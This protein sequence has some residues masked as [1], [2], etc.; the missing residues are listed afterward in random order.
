[1]GLL[2]GIGE[3][4]PELDARSRL[5]RGRSAWGLADQMTW[6]VR[7]GFVLLGIL[8]IVILLPDAVG[9]KALFLFI[10]L[11][12]LLLEGLIWVPVTIGRMLVRRRR[13][14]SA[15]YTTVTNEFSQVDQID[16]RTGRVVR[17]AGEGLLGPVEYQRRIK[18]IRESVA[19]KSGGES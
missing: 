1:M 16:P 2:S 5:L 14:V 19:S 10:V 17:L 6:A 12:L 13:E 4:N 8:V 11:F 3:W 15:G 7:V 18:L 9:G